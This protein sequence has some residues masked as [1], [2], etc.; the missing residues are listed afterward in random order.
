MKKKIFFLFILF[1]IFIFFIIYIFFIKNTAKNLNIGNNNNSQEIVNKFLNISSYEAIIE[2]EVQSNKNINKYKIKQCYIDKKNNYQEII[3]PE[4]IQGVKI[5][6]KD[7][8]LTISNSKLNLVTMF[9]NYKYL[10]ENNFD[11]FSFVND[12]LSNNGSRFYEENN[13]IIMKT[14]STNTNEYL[15]N[16]E[17]Y[18]DKKTCIPVKMVIN[19]DNKKEAIFISYNEVKIN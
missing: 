8:K 15:K 17:L 18:I 7:N 3:E 12:Y 10:T 11:L 19:S 14:K 16:K 6:Y 5:E 1:F 9:E 4:N 13:Y 2:M